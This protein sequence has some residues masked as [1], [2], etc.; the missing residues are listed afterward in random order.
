ML[1]PMPKKIVTV[2][3]FQRKTKPTFD[4]ISKSKTP[5]LV[6]NRNKQVGIFMNPKVYNEFL[7][8]YED[9]VDSKDLEEAVYVLKDEPTISLDELLESTK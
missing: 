4:D 2:S 6:L 1:N 8:M 9:Y 3:D 5:V 7:E